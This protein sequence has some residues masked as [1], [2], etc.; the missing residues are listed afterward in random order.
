VIVFL[1]GATGFIGRQLVAALLSAGHEVICASHRPATHPVAG[2][3]WV[4]ADFS[5]DFEPAVWLPRI[6]G[7]D[8]VV[9]CVGIFRAHGRQTF[10]ALH[11]RAPQA[12]F[13]ACVQARVPRVIQ[14][15]A[16][17]ADERATSAYHLSKKAADD[18]LAQLPLRW[19]IVQPSLIYGPGG[20]SASL[21]TLL[22][23]LP[24]IPLPGNGTQLIQPIHVDDALRALLV[25]VESEREL[26]QRVPLVG[27]APISFKEFLTAL[28]MAMHAGRP[29]FL[30]VPMRVARSAAR[31]AAALPG[32]LLD[33]ESLAMLIRGNT[34]E[35]AATIRLLGH[36]PRP[37]G[38]FIPGRDASAVRAQAKLQWLLPL[39]RWNI[40]AVW[41]ATGIVS[42]GIYPTSASYELLART[43]V[44]AALQPLLLYGAATLD[45]MFGLCTLLLRRRWWLWT[46]QMAL[47][48]GYTVI[49]SIRLPQF[50]AHPYG[51]IL[52]NLPLLA[53]IWLLRE[54]ED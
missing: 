10:D 1:T 39:L 24:T 5:R 33:P 11:V 52:K 19:T 18:F 23:S 31:L 36:A 45:L 50:W 46:A 20:T 30:P 43:G 14:I 34:G 15:S 47:I 37:A 25:L 7:A 29:R 13:T 54:L 38:E 28:R 32:S 8:V 17:G 44:P 40:A 48:V 6:A 27:P 35:P 26:H 9:N 41:I 12:L 22:A 53:A 51:P 16:L 4:H 3:R 42:L 2:V 49:I 21:F